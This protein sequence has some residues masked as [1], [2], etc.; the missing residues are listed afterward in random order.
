MIQREN[1]TPDSKMNSVQITTDPSQMMSFRLL[2]ENE[3]FDKLHA[4]LTGTLDVMVVVTGIRLQANN[5]TGSFQSAIGFFGFSCF[6]VGFYFP[7]T[8]TMCC[9]NIVYFSQLFILSNL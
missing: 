1:T 5:R 7:F 2:V 8:K 4:F 3:K 9:L 6:V